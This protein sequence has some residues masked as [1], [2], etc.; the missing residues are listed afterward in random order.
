MPMLVSMYVLV[1]HTV[2]LYHVDFQ[3]FHSDL[4]PPLFLFEYTRPFHDSTVSK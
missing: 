2:H 3:T 1:R 4:F